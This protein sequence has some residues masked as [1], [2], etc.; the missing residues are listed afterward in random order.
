M[1]AMAWDAALHRLTEHADRLPA[2]ADGRTEFPFRR[3]FSAA[4]R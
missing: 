4:V 3:P 2:L 1:P